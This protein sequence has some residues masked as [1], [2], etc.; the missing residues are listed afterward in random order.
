[1][2]TD[3]C[4]TSIAGVINQGMD[5]KTGCIAAFFSVKLCPAQQNYPMHKVELFFFLTGLCNLTSPS[6]LH[7]LLSMKKIW[8]MMMMLTMSHSALSWMSMSS[9]SN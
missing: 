2:I 8:M 3:G 4:L 5:Q 1:M 6:P 9:V 7:S